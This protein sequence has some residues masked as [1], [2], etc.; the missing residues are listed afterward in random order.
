MTDVNRLFTEKG[1]RRRFRREI[2]GWLENGEVR[3]VNDRDF[4][5][6]LGILKEFCRVFTLGQSSAVRSW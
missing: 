2:M 1:L 6:M 5:V 4:G 3:Y